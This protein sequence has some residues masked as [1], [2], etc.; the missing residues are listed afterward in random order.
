MTSDNNLLY[1]DEGDA[2][3]N[4]WSMESKRVILSATCDKDVT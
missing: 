3:L 4:L 2:R 1:F